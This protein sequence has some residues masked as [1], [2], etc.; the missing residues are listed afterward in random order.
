[1]RHGMLLL[2]AYQCGMTFRT[3]CCS[4]IIAPRSIS[5]TRPPT[6]FRKV[7]FSGHLRHGSCGHLSYRKNLLEKNTDQ[8]N[9]KKTDH[10]WVGRNGESPVMILRAGFD[11]CK[12]M[13][14]LVKDL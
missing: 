3:N 13:K 9:C 4:Y 1:M 14:T 7:F 2:T 10:M 11:L 5:F 12:E 6:W 8:T